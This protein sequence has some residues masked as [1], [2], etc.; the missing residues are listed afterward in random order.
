MLTIKSTDNAWRGTK[1]GLAGLVVTCKLYQ[2]SYAVVKLQVTSSHI[3]NQAT[4]AKCSL[5]SIYCTV[6]L[7]YN[8]KVTWGNFV[9]GVTP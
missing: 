8:G 5:S 9:N 7:D 6:T 1:T 4:G 2:D 3:R